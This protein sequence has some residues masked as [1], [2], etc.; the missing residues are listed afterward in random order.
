MSGE[1]RRPDGKSREGHEPRPAHRLDHRPHRQP[2]EPTSQA[3]QPVGVRRQSRLD[4]ELPALVEQTHVEPTS[5]QIQTS[6]QHENG[7]PR[8]RSSTTRRAWHRGGPPSRSK[9]ERVDVSVIAHVARPKPSAAPA[10]VA[11]SVLDG[12]ADERVGAA[13]GATGERSGVRRGAAV[14]AGGCRRRRADTLREMAERRDFWGREVEPSRR[15][16]LDVAVQVATIVAAAAAFLYVL[17]GALLLVRFA[18]ANVPAGRAVSL[19][20]GWRPRAGVGRRRSR[21][22]S[23]RWLIPYQW[24]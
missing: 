6:V 12:G 20:A 19:G 5:T 1:R 7:P 22:N 13:R 24:P 21:Q 2:R 17:G 8:A 15:V 11:G 10:P 9:A 3:T 14:G 4:Q 23:P 18:N 16:R